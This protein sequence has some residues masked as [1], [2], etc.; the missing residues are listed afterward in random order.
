VTIALRPM[1]AADGGRVPLTH[2][3]E[4]DD[5]RRR[6]ADLGSSAILAFEGPQHVGQLQFRRYEPGV[7][8]PRGLHHPLYWADFVT[9]PRSHSGPRIAGKA[10]PFTEL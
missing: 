9:L 8:S 6:I 1:T 7:R 3:G 10:R 5:V 2:Q 4:P